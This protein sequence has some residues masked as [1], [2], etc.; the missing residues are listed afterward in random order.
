MPAK[1]PAELLSDSSTEPDA[2]R[3]LAPNVLVE[4]RHQVLSLLGKGGMGAVY[5]VYDRDLDRICALKWVPA[6]ASGPEVADHIRSEFRF[7][8][9]IRHPNVVRVFDYG[10]TGEGDAWF[11]MELIDGVHLGSVWDPARPNRLV[12]IAAD[13]ACALAHIHD[14]GIVHRDIKPQNILAVRDESEDGFVAKLLDFGLATAA[15]VQLS[16]P[17]GT[18]GYMAP[19]VLR[20]H[21]GDARSDLFGL[22]AVL[23]EAISGSP[24]F[25]TGP[26]AVDVVRSVLERELAPLHVRGPGVSPR[27]SEIVSRLLQKEPSLRYHDAAEVAAELEALATGR[28]ELIGDAAPGMI[29]GAA[30]VGRERIL[31]ELATRWHRALHGQGQTVIVL[32]EEGVGK[33]R[34]LE[35]LAVH[36]QLDGGRVIT[37]ACEAHGAHHQAQPVQQLLRRAGV[38]SAVL[39][40]GDVGTSAIESVG[41]QASA[42]AA[43]LRSSIT[44][45]LL[46]A[47]EDVHAAPSEAQELFRLLALELRADHVL[48]C[49]TLRGEAATETSG[50]TAAASGVASGRLA[51]LDGEPGVL[52]HALE[53]LG[54]ADT[55]LLV[56]RLVGGIPG[57]EAL[58]ARVWK[59]TDGNPLLVEEALRA[60]VDEGVLRRRG[61]RFVLTL[62]G[63]QMES[64]PLLP[65]G[66]V[67]EALVRR[68][69]LLDPSVLQV[70]EAAAVDGGAMTADSLVVA[71]RLPH[72]AVVAAL[73]LAERRGL[74][75]RTDE[76]GLAGLFTFAQAAVREVVYQNMDPGRRVRLHRAA[77]QRL[78]RSAGAAAA[79]AVARH[80]LAG[81]MGRRAIRWSVRAAD[82]LQ[83]Q[84]LSSR[85]SALLEAALPLVGTRTAGQSLRLGLLERIADMEM[86]L[87]RLEGAAATYEEALTVPLRHPATR[88]GA[89]LPLTIARLR[90]KR[91]DVL[92]RLGR[93][94]DARLVLAEAAELPSGPESH[95]ERL[96]IRYATAWC[97]MMQAEYAEAIEEA[98]AA[99]EQARVLGPVALLGRFHLLLAN[100]YWNCGE[101]VSSTA[102]GR[103]ALRVFRSVN[104][105]RGIADA[106]LA[107]GSAHRYKSE[108]AK[109]ATNYSMALA[110]YEQLG[111]FAYVGKCRNNLGVVNYLRGRWADA[112]KHWEAFVHVCERTGERNERILLLNNLGVLYSDRAELERA[113]ATLRQGLALAKRVGIARSEAMIEAN[114]GEVHVRKGHYSEADE[115]YLRCEAIA[116][117]IEARDELV[118][119]ARR[120]CELDLERNDMVRVRLRI[121]EALQAAGAL[122]A[123]IEEAAL[124][125][126]R[127]VVRRRLGAQVEAEADLNRAAEIA[128]TVGATLEQ[129]RVKVE[130]AMQLSQRGRAEEARATLGEA[131]GGLRELGALW[132][133]RRAEA[134]LAALEKVSADPTSADLARLLDINR[135]LGTILDLDDLLRSIID[136]VLEITG[137]ERAFI[138]VHDLDGTPV[139]K[140]VR[141]A[142]TV[143]E[144]DVRIS[145]SVAERVYRS[146]RPVCVSDVDGDASFPPTESVVALDL[147]SILCVPMISKGTT[148]GVIYTDS[149]RIATQPL[150]RAQPML[151]ALGFQAAVAI[152]NARLYEMERLRSDTIATVAHELKSP[153]TAILG[154]LSIVQRHEASLDLDLQEYLRIVVDQSQRLSRMVR[155][156][157]DLRAI[158]SGAAAWSMAALSVAELVRSSLEAVIPIADI[159]GISVVCDSLPRGYEV[160]CSRDRVQQVITNLVSNAVKFTPRGGQITLTAEVVRIERSD[161]FS[162]DPSR[163]LGPAVPP[164]HLAELGHSVPFLSKDV[165]LRIGVRDNGA[166]I[167]PADARRIFDKYTQGSS[168]RRGERG[169]GLGL[170]IA[171]EIVLRHGGRIWVEST[172]GK[173]SIFHFTLPVIERT[174]LIR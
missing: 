81:D 126:L 29:G 92:A 172:P 174:G 59:E 40:L 74:V 118:E 141:D 87:G 3:L 120:R 45:P 51:S 70:L 155:N 100:L 85:A 112:A 131:I 30:L 96:E 41:R 23:Y 24:P 140:Q 63:S 137:F 46:L 84:L 103:D 163:E 27:L 44:T 156:I 109:A 82:S 105:Q 166:G 15:E 90:R 117:E 75:R 127:A 93:L 79:E 47:I 36:V 80:F 31:S 161:A 99:R 5:K 111:V 104:H 20:G 62:S 2:N 73:R 54:Q 14:R 121:D 169:I 28:D 138:I 1:L 91:G 151:E 76:E 50:D 33:S 78:A 12:R 66:S 154:Y 77:G 107:L 153:L 6:C 149:R 135:K 150:A 124:Y 42:V 129:Q 19:E 114:L 68:L 16:R 8:A 159:Q 53:R 26:G 134:A 162:P 58:R 86:H 49:M 56:R 67:R 69:R 171:R 145:R 60:L 110:I 139:V 148:I 144:S 173:G 39:Q 61:G 115:C 152:E 57:E 83:A 55:G 25:A 22:G 146:G 7:I 17:S 64:V 88:R 113:E 98:I 125:R 4:G 34:L 143:D 35:E 21:A 32:G 52:V 160:F 65:R 130:R 128:A 116:T 168:E 136:V 89:A 164:P 122:G 48:T 10:V 147:R 158:E 71:A 72:A 101:W 95:V 94:D 9:T 108:Y 38:P 167:A 102:S 133:V 142:G 18:L 43:A 165:C 170:S 37:V 119:L 13:L 106:Y 157:L 123:R 132:E 11:T 97:R